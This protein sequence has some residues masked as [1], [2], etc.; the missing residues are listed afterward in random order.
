MEYFIVPGLMALICVVLAT[1]NHGWIRAFCLCCA[2]ANL[3]VP[4]V[5]PLFY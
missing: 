1:I 3:V 4:I 2:A 5:M